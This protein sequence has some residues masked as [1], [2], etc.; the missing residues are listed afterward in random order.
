MPIS[1]SVCYLCCVRLRWSICKELFSPHILTFK[2]VEE[3]HQDDLLYDTAYKED[4][5][6]DYKSEDGVTFNGNG[7]S[8]NGNNDEDKGISEDGDETFIDNFTEY[9]NFQ[10]SSLSSSSSLYPSPSTSV[11]PHERPYVDEDEHRE[12]K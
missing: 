12:A 7:R 4:N 9:M 1:V 6:D 11:L 5:D 3:D 2:A 10:C 8:G